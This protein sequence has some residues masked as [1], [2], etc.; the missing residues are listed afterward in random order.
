MV[1]NVDVNVV[2]FLLKWLNEIDF[3]C[4]VNLIIVSDYGMDNMLVSC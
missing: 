2:G 1:E 3:L 4:K